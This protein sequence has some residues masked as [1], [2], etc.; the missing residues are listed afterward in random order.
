[1]PVM[2]GRPRH[3]ETQYSERLPRILQKHP[4]ILVFTGNR[5]VL[6]ARSLSMSVVVGDVD[7]APPTGRARLTQ[8][9]DRPAAHQRFASQPRVGIDRNRVFN[10][11]E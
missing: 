2:W 8:A 4:S 1:M 6:A 11:G 10:L 7:N 9:D 3:K 5:F